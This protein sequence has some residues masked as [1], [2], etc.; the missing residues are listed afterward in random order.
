VESYDQV[1]SQL[2]ALSVPPRLASV[3]GLVS[4]AMVEQRTALAEWRK[5]ALPANLA[6]HPLVA[7]SS[8]KL[9]RGATHPVSAGERAQQGRVL[10]LPLRDGLHL[11][12]RAPRGRGR[13]AV[14]GPGWPVQTATAVS[15]ADLVS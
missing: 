1:V 12:I 9:H 6:G 14:L 2:D 15:P 7:S 4:E 11:G 5:T 8:G 10:R 3:H 13:I